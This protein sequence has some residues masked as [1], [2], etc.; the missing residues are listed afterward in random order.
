MPHPTLT[1]DPPRKR[2]TVEFEE[3]PEL[4]TLEAISARLKKDEARSLHVTVSLDWEDPQ[5]PD[6]DDPRQV[7]QLEKVL[8]PSLETFIFD[9]PFD[10]HVR[11]SYNTLGD[12]C[13]VL[14][15]CPTLQRA[16]I[17][18]C[19]TMRKTRH[20]HIRELHL[21]GEPLDSSV[22]PALAAS[23]FLREIKSMLAGLGLHL[24]MEV[25]GWPPENIG[26]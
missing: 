4:D 18:G 15:A 6:W 21:M 19:S 10:S 1:F 5:A 8:N 20:E 9:N 12:I 23:Q 2:M 16:F 25:S 3:P 13:D 14:A 17:T 7:P 22:V 24:G 26:R 11:Q